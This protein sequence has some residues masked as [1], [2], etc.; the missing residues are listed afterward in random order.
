MFDPRRDNL[1]NITADD[2]HFE[3]SLR[4]FQPP[5]EQPEE[6]MQSAK[7]RPG[8]RVSAGVDHVLSDDS[9]IRG[10]LKGELFKS[11]EKSSYYAESENTE[12]LKQPT[13]GRPDYL[14]KKETM[15]P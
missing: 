14:E 2:S 11:F 12:N 13:S 9:V 15:N 3:Q 6:S 4:Q 8:H 1:L 5:L 10:F 7:T